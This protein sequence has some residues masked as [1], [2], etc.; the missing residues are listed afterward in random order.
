[1]KKRKT[2]RLPVR[3][4]RVP[5]P[6]LRPRGTPRKRRQLLTFGIWAEGLRA[7]AD[8]DSALAFEKFADVIAQD[9]GI[10]SGDQMVEATIQFVAQKCAYGVFGPDHEDPKMD[11]LLQLQCYSMQQ[12]TAKYWMLLSPSGRA[13]PARLLS[14][15]VTFMDLGDLVV[16]YG[17]NHLRIGHCDESPISA[18]EFD[19][20]RKEMRHSFGFDESELD[21]KRRGDHI[22]VTVSL[23]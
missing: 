23:N 18:R 17:I 3:G 11:D 6:G 13:I 14:N 1:M 5:K 22:V 21:F 20:L 8:E 10:V 12:S 16:C 9:C 4:A 15:D 19:R 2:L 7:A